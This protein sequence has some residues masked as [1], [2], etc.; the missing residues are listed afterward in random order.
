L[1][2]LLYNSGARIQEALDLRPKDLHLESPAH[3]RLYGQRSK[4]R[5]ARC[6]RN[7]GPPD[8]TAASHAAIAGRG[9]VQNRYGEPL[10]AS[11]FRFRLRQYVKAAIKKVPSLSEKRVTPTYFVTQPPCIW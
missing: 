9:S 10:T 8:G 3:V 4:E 2:S 5:I 6:G 7:G 11:G 1:L